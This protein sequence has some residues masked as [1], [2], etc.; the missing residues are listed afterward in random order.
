MA[1]VFSRTLA[2][3]LWGMAAVALALGASPP[4]TPW[5]VTLLGIVLIAFAAG[6][7]TPRLRRVR[8]EE[9]GDKT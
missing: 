2:L 6:G 1:V 9:R 8:V 5:L 3:P 7:L 4:A